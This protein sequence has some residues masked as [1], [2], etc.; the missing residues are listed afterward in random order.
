MID[1]SLESV[2]YA[3][4]DLFTKLTEMVH[5]LRVDGTYS[6]DAIKQTLFNDIVKR[7]TGMNVSL[8][9]LDFGGAV[10]AFASL[11]DLNRNHPFMKVHEWLALRENEG[12]RL[13]AMSKKE[14]TGAVNLSTSTVSGVYSELPLTMAVFLGL[15]KNTLFTPGEVAAIILHEL[16]HLFTYFQYINTIG[17]GGLVVQI[18]AKE[19]VGASSKEERVDKLRQAEKVLGVDKIQNIN[20]DDVPS[21]EGVQVVLFRNYLTNMYSSTGVAQYDF[22]NCEQ[23]A[24]QF[25]TKHGSGRD[26]VTGLDKMFSLA[27]DSSKRSQF[28]FIVVETCKLIAFIGTLASGVGVP[29]ALIALLVSQPSGYKTYDDPEAR[30]RF[31][32]QQLINS[33]SD[34]RKTKGLDETILK[35]LIEDVEVVDG[36]LETIK[37]RRTLAQLFWQS[38][39]S[40]AASLRKQEMAVKQLETLLFNDLEYQS[41]RFELLTK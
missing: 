22:R 32:R 20:L 33:I 30:V 11:P 7:H 2:S 21:E 19:I 5:F 25:A 17:W 14:M 18:A 15:I 38:L 40:A 10:N 9:I 8:N 29:I 37:D 6:T 34:V 31:I 12:T 13:A 1:I 28:S 24:D 23:L 3:G 36:V 26:L 27:G 16:G 4:K 35:G 39:P 41:T